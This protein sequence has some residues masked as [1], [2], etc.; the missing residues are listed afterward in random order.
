MASGQG[1][2]ECSIGHLVGTAVA[3]G[4]ARVCR[5]G[6]GWK[7]DFKV[8]VRRKQRHQ[9][10]LQEERFTGQFSPLQQEKI[11]P[12]LFNWEVAPTTGSS[13]TN[14]DILSV[15]NTTTV[16]SDLSNSY[17]GT[18]VIHSN[19]LTKGLHHEQCRPDR[20]SFVKIVYDNVPSVR[21]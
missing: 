3:G 2:I 18:A 6:Q 7:V 1:W 13:S 12:F 8:G 21:Y 11:I 10:S 9:Q 17:D 15:R 20:D 5:V 16:K 19:S 4:A 14:W